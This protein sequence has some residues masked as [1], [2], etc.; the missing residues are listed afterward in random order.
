MHYTYHEGN[1][2]Q[3]RRRVVRSLH[4]KEKYIVH[5]VRSIFDGTTEMQM[6]LAFLNAWAL[7]GKH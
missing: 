5:F 1:L 7:A 6:I 4:A 3:S 2:A